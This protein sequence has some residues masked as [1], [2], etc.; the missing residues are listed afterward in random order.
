MLVEFA[1]SYARKNLILRIIVGFILGAVL[2]IAAL[3]FH[4]G[5]LEG[6]V[7]FAGIL[8][9]LF[10]KALK[11]IAPILVFML[12]L[13]SIITKTFANAKGLKLVIWLYVIGTFLASLVAVGFS[14]MFPVELILPENSENLEAPAGIAEVL[15]N[16]VFKIVDNPVN[17]VASGN[18]IGIL[19]WSIGLGIALRIAAPTTKEFFTDLSHALIKV[20]RFIIQLAPIGVFGIVAYSVATLGIDTLASYLRITV[21]LVCAMLFVALIVNPLIVFVVLKKN[22]F[23]LV[24]KCLGRSGLTAFFTRS[25]A[26]NVPVNMELC[27]KMKLD[28]ELYPISI[29]LGATINMAGAAV[30][31]AILTLGAVF[32]LDIETDFGTALL[33]C[34]LATV[35]ACGASGVP[36][37]SLMLIPLACSLFN[38][39][40]DTAMQVIAIGF[41]IGVIQDSL[42]TAIN[43]STDVIF[44]AVASYKTNE[45]LEYNPSEFY[46]EFDE[47]SDEI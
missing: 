23:P 40:N 32:A 21:L 25:S 16:L 45:N 18:F 20:V 29:P 5:W 41:A 13:N 39:G 24:F 46:E 11:A 26:A 4:T 30:T 42:E 28:E 1:Q 36:G 9:D 22:P 6:L 19:A 27:Q 37:G 2:G 14:F 10:A 35:G 15:R 47:N 33:L 12:I 44:T 8:G 3:K 34:V 31:I 38:I 17:A 43:S 7:A